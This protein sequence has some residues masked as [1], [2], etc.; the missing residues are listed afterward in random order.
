MH[1]KQ[2]FKKKIVIVGAGVGG[3]YLAYLLEDKFDITI[4]EARER[5][6]GRIQSKRPFWREKGLSG[7]VFS[8]VG[9]LGEIHDACEEDKYALFGFVSVHTDM[10]NF[11]REVKAQ[12]IRLF[13]IRE[14]DIKAVYLLDWR[15][16]QFSSSYED[17]KVLSAHPQ[18]GIDTSEYSKKILFSATEFSYD[19]GGYIEGAISLA[20][21]L[22][23]EL[24]HG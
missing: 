1:Q 15:E 4:V 9:P 24:L 3:L 16:E 19:N 13:K 6:G 11:K 7:F 8:Y 18:Y 14:S 21:K 22:S 23:K 2:N 17:K 10:L 12:M 5:I 20:N